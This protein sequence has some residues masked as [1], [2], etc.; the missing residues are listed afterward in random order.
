M[1]TSP[2]TAIRRLAVGRAVSVTGWEAGWIALM[3]AVYAK[4]HSTVW[5]SAALFAVIATESIVGPFAGALGDRYDRRKVLIY[6]ELAAACVSLVMVFAESPLALVLLAAVVAV[7]ESPFVP[8]SNAAVP[9]LAGTERLEWANSNVAIGRNIGSLLG[10]LVGGVVAAWAGAPTV[11]AL[12]TVGFV[13][14]AG[15]VF[16][17]TGNFGG[18]EMTSS[19]RSELRKGFA[20]VWN[21][22]VLRGMTGA[23]I[24]LLFLLGPILVAELPLAHEFGYGPGG[25]GVIAACWGGGAIVGSFLGRRLARLS[26]SGTM[27]FGCVG[28]AAGFALVSVAPVIGFAMLGMVFSGVSEGAVS[29]AEQTIIQRATPDAVRSRVNAA[30]EAV[31]MSAFALSFLVAG[32]VIDVAGVRGAYGLAALG[33]LLAAGILVPAMRHARLAAAEVAATH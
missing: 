30:A 3:T 29:V 2:T 4:T 32:P 23:W 26:E 13:I 20:F 33:S 16:S 15:F 6:C 11:F 27:I 12:A 31:A 21:S 14:S 22:P 18:G 1:T 25:Y 17:T 10:P 7:A 8:T 28:I 5:M 19:D 9:N 24:V